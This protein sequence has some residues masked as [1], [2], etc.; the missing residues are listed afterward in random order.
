MVLVQFQTF[1][2][3]KRHDLEFLQQCGKRVKTKNYVN[4]GL[5]ITFREV[6]GVKAGT[7]GVIF[8]RIGL[9]KT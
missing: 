7:G 2:T 6:T 9:I 1:G 4:L 3:S 8:P 5:I